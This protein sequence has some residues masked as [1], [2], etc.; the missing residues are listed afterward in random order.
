MNVY[1]VIVGTIQLREVIIGQSVRYLSRRDHFY[2]FLGNDCIFVDMMYMYPA[3][4]FIVEVFDSVFVFRSCFD[5][6]IFPD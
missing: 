4:E 6:N 5:I 1:V 3:A 2:K